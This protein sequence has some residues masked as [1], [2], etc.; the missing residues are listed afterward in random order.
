[1]KKLEAESRFD[2]RG[3]TGQSSDS[4]F[5]L[6]RIDD[7][8][9]TLFLDEDEIDEFSEISFRQGFNLRRLRTTQ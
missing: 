5:I 2:Y 3:R 7:L 9:S 4:R 8:D 1:M 6:G